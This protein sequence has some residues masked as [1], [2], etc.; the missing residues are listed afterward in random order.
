M[1]ILIVFPFNQII[2]L[3][4]ENFIKTN[5]FYNFHFSIS[6]SSDMSIFLVIGDVMIDRYYFAK[7]E[8]ISPEA[9]I[10]IH[11]IQKMEDKLGGAGNVADNLNQLKEDGDEVHLISVLGEENKEDIYK[12]EELCKKKDIKYTFFKEDDRKTTVK[13]RIYSDDHL[14]S[15]FDIETISP[16]SAKYRD[17]ILFYVNTHINDFK[18]ILFSDYQKGVLN[19]SLCK[20]IIEICKMKGKRVYVDPKVK[21]VEKY[22]CAFLLK[23]NRK[24]TDGILQSNRIHYEE[25]LISFLQISHLVVTEGKDGMVLYSKNQKNSFQVTHTEKDIKVKDVTGCG[26]SVFAALVY[27]YETLYDGTEEDDMETIQMSVD[28]ANFIGEKSVGNIGTYCC[29]KKDIEEFLKKRSY[30]SKVN[31]FHF[32]QETEY[33]QKWI[34]NLKQ[35]YK[36]I[37]FTNGC[38]DVIHTGHLKLLHYA[39]KCGDYL[40]LALNSDKSIKRLKGESR[41]IHHEEDRIDFQ[42]NLKI[43][44]AIILFEEDTPERLLSILK[45]N[46]MIKGGD[47]TPSSVL[48]REYCEEVKIFDFV[49]GYSST[50]TIQ[51]IKNQK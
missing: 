10:P 27:M 17:E 44:D 39:K 26:D 12:I 29:S 50:K 5:R 16:I 38:F 25:D 19:I 37:V 3:Y 49:D 15:R 2:F 35:K 46:I 13:N 11:Q 9:P 4:K 31:I 24:E 28:F 33:L 22:R 40:I 43:A 18:C 36:K 1:E 41:P 20:K 14:V 6:L 8:R 42:K 7:T 32:N 30:Q 45:P 21:D 48:G 34:F 47:Y 23:P 51:K